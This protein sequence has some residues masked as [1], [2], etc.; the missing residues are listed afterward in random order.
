MIDSGPTGGKDGQAADGAGQPENLPYTVELWSTGGAVERVL[1]RA[2]SAQ[3][4]Q[5]IYK[6]AQTEHPGQRVTIR[7]GD[8][9]IADTQG[10]P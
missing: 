9:L 7:R 6:A 4:A 5:A 2:H 8:K 3:L 10:E 1:A